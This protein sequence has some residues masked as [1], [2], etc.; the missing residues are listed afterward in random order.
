MNVMLADGL[1]L[2]D[3][4]HPAGTTRAQARTRIR[5]SLC[6]RAAQYF[7][8]DVER[9]AVVSAPGQPPRLLLDGQ[10]FD[11]GISISHAATRSLAV[12]GHRMRVGIDLMEIE[13]VDDWRA[14][15]RD[16]LG[17][18]ALLRLDA[19]AESDRMPA[20]AH[21][22]TAREACLKCFGMQ[23]AEWN[24]VAM[25]CTLLTLPAGP[26]HAASLACLARRMDQ[27]A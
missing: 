8:I 11:A 3:L 12:I 17:P 26:G 1:V 10:P 18:Q 22:W 7:G 6:A 24:D 19:E 16:Y 2:V 14:L 27:S 25:S 9:L 13:Q 15:A 23:L 21:E 5:T 4:D 20:L